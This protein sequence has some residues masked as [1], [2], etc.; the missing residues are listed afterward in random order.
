MSIIIKT[1]LASDINKNINNTI[2]QEKKK[3]KISKYNKIYDNKENPSTLNNINNKNNIISTNT[4]NTNIKGPKTNSSIAKKDNIENKNSCKMGN[5]IIIINHNKK[6]I[7]T[8][9]SFNEIITSQFLNRNNT[10]KSSNTKEF[11]KIKG[12]FDFN[13]KKSFNNKILVKTSNN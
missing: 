1:K 6:R 12:N 5:N 7:T 2:A 10:I 8:N 3:L 11:N 4:Y 13:I 9:I